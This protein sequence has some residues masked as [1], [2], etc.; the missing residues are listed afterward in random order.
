MVMNMKET[1][2]IGYRVH[3]IRI[4]HGLSQEQLAFAA[5]ITPNYLGQIERNLKCPTI[6]IIEQICCAMNISLTDFFSPANIP[7]E[8]DAFTMQLVT[9]MKN[10]TDEE[11][12]IIINIIKQLLAFNDTNK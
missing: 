4:E 11:K 5:N 1:F 3:Q 6:R 9:L 10:R 7:S 8:D 12:K 2:N